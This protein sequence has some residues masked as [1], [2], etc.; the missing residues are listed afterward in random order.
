MLAKLIIVSLR[1][2][3]CELT[4]ILYLCELKGGAERE[5]DEESSDMVEY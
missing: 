3:S 2:N 4:C 5:V 1:N